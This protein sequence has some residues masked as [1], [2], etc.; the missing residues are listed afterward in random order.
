MYDDTDPRPPLPAWILECYEC[1]RTKGAEG[2]SSFP[3]ERA[4][5]LLLEAEEVDLEPVDVE[6]A[7]VRLLER[8]YLY[9]VDDELRITPVGE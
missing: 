6:H 2:S 8:G 1:L 7:L 4:V 9:E 3:R 5:E